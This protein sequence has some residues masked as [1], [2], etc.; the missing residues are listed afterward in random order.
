MVS[1]DESSSLRDARAA[2]FELNDLGADGGYASKWI[3]LKLLGTTLAFPNWDARRDAVKLHDLHHLATGYDTSWSGETQISAFEIASGCGSYSAAWMLNLS[4]FFVG[5]VT[6]P[7]TMF[8]AFRRG[9]RARNLYSE[10]YDEALLETSVGHT[11]DRLGL[12]APVPPT[13]AADCASFALWWMV[14]ALVSLPQLA[15]VLAPL[16]LLLWL[17]V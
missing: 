4:A 1:Y 9:R 17:V 5:I 7:R 3:K 6:N 16:F 11:R 15:L 10:G 14:S 2:Y 8:E 12:R 13:T